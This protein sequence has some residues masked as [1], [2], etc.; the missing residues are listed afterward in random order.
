MSIYIFCRPVHSGKTTALLEWCNQQENIAGV[1][2]PDINGSRKIFDI[3]SKEIFDIECAD[4]INTKEPLI[5]AG[6]FLFYTA[7][8]ERAN[9]I[10]INAMGQ[11]LHWL[12]IDEAGK[13]ELEGE[14]FYSS[15]VRALEIYDNNEMA[16]N[17]LMTV[18][19]SLCEAAIS[20]FEIQHYRIIEGLE[21]IDEP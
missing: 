16:G 21:M 12:V 13:L 7:A 15:I 17:L 11:N 18:R 3:H 10:L 8:F 14:G 5:T 20:F 4:A 9:S 19:D 6:R 1:L 2:M